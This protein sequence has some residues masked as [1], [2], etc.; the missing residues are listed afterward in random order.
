MRRYVQFNLRDLLWAM[1]LLGFALAWWQEYARAS[2]KAKE[3]ES[4]L[5][6]LRKAEELNSLHLELA[7]SEQDRFDS[8]RSEMEG[9]LIQER[10]L[11]RY[12]ERK[13]RG[14]EASQLPPKCID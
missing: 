11:T 7:D 12:L 2:G 13:L 4:L 10:N 9:R 1:L 6:A 8:M 5:S 14:L 3:A